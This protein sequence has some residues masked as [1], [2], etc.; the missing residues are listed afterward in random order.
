MLEGIVEADETYIGGKNKKDYDR[1]D[2]EPKNM[3]AA[4]RKTLCLAQLREVE[5]LSQHS[6]RTRLARQSKTSSNLSSIPMTSN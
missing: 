4:L 5:R 6:C 1:E 2:G 3:D